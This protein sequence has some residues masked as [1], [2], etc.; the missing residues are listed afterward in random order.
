MADLVPEIIWTATAD[1]RID[2]VNAR[3]CQYFDCDGN[4]TRYG[5][6]LSK[7]HRDD[8]KGLMASWRQSLYNG[9]PFEKK[10]R[11]EN[12]KGGYEWHLLKAAL[13]LDEA[14]RLTNWFGSCANID[15]HVQDMKKKDEFI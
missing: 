13:F 3:F 8:L 4:D 2:Y 10:V 1:G 9:T 12:V 15:V 7:V 11:L 5:F 14:G 6:I